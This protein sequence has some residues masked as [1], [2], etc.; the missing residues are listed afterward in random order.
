MEEIPPSTPQ[1]KELDESL[2]VNCQAYPYEDGHA[3]NLCSSC[4]N[5]L[6]NYPIP[7][8]IK[9]FAIVLVG[10][11]VVSLVRTQFYISA[12]INLGKGEKAIESKNYVTAQNELSKVVSEFPNDFTSNGNLLIAASY[13]LDFPTASAAYEKI[14][15]IKIEDEAFIQSITTAMNYM[16]ENI[17]QDTVISK[18]I[19]SAKNNST[20]L[21]K[22][23]ATLK[24][25][26]EP[27]VNTLIADYLYDL[28]EFN[29]S[30][31]ILKT[32]LQTKP[33]YY[34]A[35]TLLSAI[36]RSTGKYDEAIA[37]CNQ[38]LK[39]NAQ[40]IYVISCKARIELK[41]KH[42]KQAAVY[43][44]EAIKINP[45]DDS[46]LEALAMVNYFSGN[47]KQSMANLATINSHLPFNRDS[48]ISKRLTA[49]LNGSKIYR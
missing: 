1:E 3:I 39:T 45:T 42:D 47:K 31:N 12:A 11:I 40:N 46:A 17:T 20:A 38:V 9:I 34:G 32:I 23:Y 6:I 4:R 37:L 5:E 43:A 33:D 49:I 19:D 21:L 29:A 24:Q 28:E 7:K 30:E 16:T 36:K 13:N 27:A 8:W 25:N 48:T 18:R 14:A 15:S 41:R 44:Q 2:C 35:L 26:A 10:V 22:L